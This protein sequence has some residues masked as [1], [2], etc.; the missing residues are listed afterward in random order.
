M[1]CLLLQ[2]QFPSLSSSSVAVLLQPSFPLWTDPHHNS[3][4]LQPS[5][6]KCI[7]ASQPPTPAV[8]SWEHTNWTGQGNRYLHHSLLLSEPNPSVLHLSLQQNTCCILSFPSAHTSCRSH[9]LSLPTPSPDLNVLF[10]APNSSRQSLPTTNHSYQGSMQVVF[11]NSLS[12][13]SSSF[14]SLSCPP[15]YSRPSVTLVSMFPHSKK[16]K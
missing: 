10:L 6:L 4:L 14:N 13:C 16:M 15:K 3:L 5:F 12:F 9:R 7:P 8:I 2:I 11:K 1:L